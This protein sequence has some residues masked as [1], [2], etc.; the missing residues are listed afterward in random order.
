MLGEVAVSDSKAAG[1]GLFRGAVISMAQMGERQ[2]LMQ[3][4][5][6]AALGE[7]LCEKRF[8]SLR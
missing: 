5:L 8:L 3:A 4:R 7:G 1:T 6:V 2:A